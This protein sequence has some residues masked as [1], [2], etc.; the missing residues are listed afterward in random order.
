M[1][2]VQIKVKKRGKVEERWSCVNRLV[3]VKNI[4]VNLKYMKERMKS[5]YLPLCSSDR[6]DDLI[7]N[8]GLVERET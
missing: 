3:V 5:A 1:S 7:H 6:G 8:A 4:E 2:C